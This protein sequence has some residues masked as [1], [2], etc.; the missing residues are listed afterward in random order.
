MSR[1]LLNGYIKHVSIRELES[2]GRLAYDSEDWNRKFR[3]K[4][5]PSRAALLGDGAATLLE[6]PVKKLK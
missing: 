2:T 1:R 4:S 6:R 3:A 5:R